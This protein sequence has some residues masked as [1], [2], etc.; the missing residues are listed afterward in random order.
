[1]DQGDGSQ[2]RERSTIKQYREHLDQ[3]IVPI[4]GRFKLSDLNVPTVRKFEDQLREKVKTAAMVRKVMVSL[5]SILAD[6]QEQGL[7]AAMPSASYGAIVG[8]MAARAGRKSSRSELI[9]RHQ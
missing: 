7:A 9:F 3:H 6:A 2:G 5:G 8:R 1:M 4:I